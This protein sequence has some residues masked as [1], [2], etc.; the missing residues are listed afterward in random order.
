MFE[1]HSNQWSPTNI[2]LWVVEARGNEDTFTL[3]YYQCNNVL[4]SSLVIGKQRQRERL[5]KRR[6]EEQHSPISKV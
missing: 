2:S 1:Q 4:I 3:V 6:W 5:Q